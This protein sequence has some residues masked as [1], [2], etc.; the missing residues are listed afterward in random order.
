MFGMESFGLGADPFN[1]AAAQFT[2]AQ[3]PDAAA[4]F[5]ARLGISPTDIFG[6][7]MSLGA[8][9]GGPAPMGPPTPGQVPI[10][11]TTPP[12][13]A[14]DPTAPEKPQGN[15][16]TMALGALGRGVVA[17]KQGSAD[18]KPQFSGGITQA[19]KADMPQLGVKAGQN[20][21][22]AMALAQLMPK[23]G[24]PVPTLGGLLGGRGYG[25]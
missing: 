16:L 19:A 5:F 12:E 6:P 23:A 7:K 10:G 8:A 13:A 4:N 24:G 14:A 11:T 21:A 22:L 25:I 1:Q 2:A 17:G 18:I 20:S 3:N 15:N 9:M